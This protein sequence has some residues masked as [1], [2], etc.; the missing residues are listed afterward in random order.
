MT[1]G[2]ALV[3][4]CGAAGATAWTGGW[5]EASFAAPLTR[6]L[7]GVR[8]GSGIVSASGPGSEGASLDAFR[9]P[10][11]DRPGLEVPGAGATGSAG[12]AGSRA[13]R[14][15]ENVGGGTMSGLTV[16]GCDPAVGIRGAGGLGAWDDAVQHTGSL[17]SGGANAGQWVDEA[18]VALTSFEL[19]NLARDG[20][21]PGAAAGDGGQAG[22]ANGELEAD[23]APRSGAGGAVNLTSPCNSAAKPLKGAPSRAPA[24]SVP[25]LAAVSG[26]LAVTFGGG[27]AKGGPIG[28]DEWAGCAVTGLF[29]H[30][31]VPVASSGPW[32]PPSLSAA[33]SPLPG[34]NAPANFAGMAVCS[35]QGKDSKLAKGRAKPTARG[36]PAYGT[37][38]AVTGP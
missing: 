28:F 3:T 15:A 25:G 2:W 24:A 22:T 31:P 4:V 6:G 16:S 12:L 1:S 13:T 33:F 7:G 11:S 26:R 32:R 35:A 21:T 19:A 37:P 23:G 29:L 10:V 27:G 9:D 17:V 30:C 36:A 18:G 5:F 8:V 34:N 14:S 38:P 20:G